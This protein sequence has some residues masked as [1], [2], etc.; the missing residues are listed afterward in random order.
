MFPGLVSLYLRPEEP[1]AKRSRED[2]KD[3]NLADIS[4]GTVTS[5][6]ARER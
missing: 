6:R 3:F 2:E 5:V 1:D 4:E